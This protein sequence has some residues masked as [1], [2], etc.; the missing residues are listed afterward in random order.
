MWWSNFFSKLDCKEQNGYASIKPDLGT[1]G[2][3]AGAPV[4]PSVC[5]PDMTRYTPSSADQVARDRAW[6]NTCSSLTAA[7]QADVRIQIILKIKKSLELF[8]NSGITNWTEHLGG[9]YT[10]FG[11]LLISY[12]SVLFKILFNMIFWIFNLRMP[13]FLQRCK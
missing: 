1:P 12:F 6:M 3:G 7:A 4:R 5:T 8:S 13:R 9:S 11:I 10:S 2:W